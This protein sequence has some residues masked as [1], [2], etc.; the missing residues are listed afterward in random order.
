[1]PDL[2]M[3]KAINN[4]L[5]P[6]EIDA[7]RYVRALKT[8]EDVMVTI[9]KPRNIQFHRKFF[10]LLRLAYENQD[11]YDTF[12]AFRHEVTLRSGFF[13][14]HVHVTGKISYLPKSLS[15]D[16]MDELEFGKLYQKAID[17]IIKHFMV[18]TDPDELARQA[19]GY[20][21]FA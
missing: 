4:T 1:M 13:T 20:V 6:S 11:K 15:F 8:G 3:R 10:A 17:V 5:V 14:E 12:E 16:N 19:E 18:G 2:Y 21:S 9:K 7:A